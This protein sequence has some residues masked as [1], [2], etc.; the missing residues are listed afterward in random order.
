MTEKNN[1]KDGLALVVGGLFI[2]ALVFATYNYFSKGKENAEEIRREEE[3]VEQEATQNKGDLNGNGATTST[4]T[5]DKGL[6]T[7]G[8]IAQE[9]NTWKA[10]NYSTGDIKGNSYTVVAGDTLWE[11]A[12]AVYG[13]GTQ[14][15][16]IL[17]ANSGSIGFLPNGQQA[18]I[19]PGQVLVL[20]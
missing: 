10:N 9:Q 5:E 7:G 16:K 2:L 14:W 13:D 12:E 18:L 19:I 3:R 17:N 20:P 11:I 6:G 1:S 4:I 15:V 8:P